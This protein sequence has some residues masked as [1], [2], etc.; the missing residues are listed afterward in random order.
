[1]CIGIDTGRK[2]IRLLEKGT[3]IAESKQARSDVLL[4]LF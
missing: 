3:Q 2:G 4:T 1:M